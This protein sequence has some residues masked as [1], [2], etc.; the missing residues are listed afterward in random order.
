[1]SG[2][3]LNGEGWDLP[4]GGKSLAFKFQDA[5]DRG[6]GPGQLGCVSSINHVRLLALEQILSTS[7]I[8]IVANRRR[9]ESTPSQA[10]H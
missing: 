3:I 8:M 10:A 1:M 5:T 6:T 9:E 2:S 7:L 4:S